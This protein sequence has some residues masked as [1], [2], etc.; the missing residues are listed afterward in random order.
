MICQALLK[1]LGILHVTRW[2]VTS[3]IF[4]A[5]K[6]NLSVL[7]SVLSSEL[8]ICACCHSKQ[9]A[10]LGEMEGPSCQTDPSSTGKGLHHSVIT[11]SLP[12]FHVV[13]S[14]FVFIHEEESGNGSHW[15]IPVQSPLVLL[16]SRCVSLK[17]FIMKQADVVFLELIHGSDEYGN[18][19]EKC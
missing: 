6:L 9:L 11:S 1:T 17:F 2:S 4:R 13:P 3:K 7:C 19:L 15:Q 12:V 14:P 5:F 16:V 10:G 18:F 8:H